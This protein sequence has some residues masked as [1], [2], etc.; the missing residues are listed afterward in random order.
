[1]WH[2]WRSREEFWGKPEGKGLYRGLLVRPSCVPKNVGVN[3]KSEI[4][5]G[6]P[7]R[8]KGLV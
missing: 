3:Q 8:N 7:I 6:I 1:M 2:M 5:N 4:K